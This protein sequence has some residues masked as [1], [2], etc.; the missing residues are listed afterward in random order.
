[1]EPTALEA[2]ATAHGWAATVTVY[3]EADP[4]AQLHGYRDGLKAHAIRWR[5]TTAGRSST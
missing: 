2:L 4:G 1:M 3:G 5:L